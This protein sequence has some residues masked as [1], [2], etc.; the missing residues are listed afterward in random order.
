[1]PGLWDKDDAH[2]Q[3]PNGHAA[4]QAGDRVRVISAPC[5]RDQHHRGKHGEIIEVDHLPDHEGG[6][7]W[8][9]RLDDDTIVDWHRD[10]FAPCRLSRPG[11]VY[12]VHAYPPSERRAEDAYAR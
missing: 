5:S 10:C 12:H 3:G 8:K 4:A 11:R 7:F 1:M 6:T 2:L 9:V